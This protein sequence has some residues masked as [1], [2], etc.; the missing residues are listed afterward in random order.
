M[1][2]RQAGTSILQQRFFGMSS[3]A[4]NKL[5]GRLNYV[6]GRLGSTSKEGQDLTALMAIASDA[7]EYSR[8]LL[9]HEDKINQVLDEASEN[10]AK[11]RD[12]PS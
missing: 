8:R 7:V 12:S 10:E 3:H 1:T 6:V 9:P 2:S 4:I 11:R 5:I